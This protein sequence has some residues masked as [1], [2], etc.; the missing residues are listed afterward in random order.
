MKCRH[1]R[2]ITKTE[3]IGF[4]PKLLS[5]SQR[6]LQRYCTRLNAVIHT[7]QV[8]IKCNTLT[9]SSPLKSEHVLRRCVRAGIGPMTSSRRK[10]Y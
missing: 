6:L 3:I 9:Q 5:N 8:N 4:L 1:I 10:L 7:Q 2:T